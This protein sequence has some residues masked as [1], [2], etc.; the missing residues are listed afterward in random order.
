MKINKNDSAIMGHRLQRTN[1][2]RR[3]TLIHYTSPNTLTT[4]WSFAV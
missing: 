1:P 4:D 3:T 2:V